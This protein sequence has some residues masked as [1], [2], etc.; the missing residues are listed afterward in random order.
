MT[1][2]SKQGL[3]LTFDDVSR[4]SWLR[5]LWKAWLSTSGCQGQTLAEASSSQFEIRTHQGPAVKDLLLNVSGSLLTPGLNKTTISCEYMTSPIKLRETEWKF[6]RLGTRDKG[7]ENIFQVDEVMWNWRR[8]F[9]ISYVLNYVCLVHLLNSSSTTKEIF[10]KYLKCSILLYWTGFW[11]NTTVSFIC[12]FVFVSVFVFAFVF[13]YFMIISVARP[14][15]HTTALSSTLLD[16][17]FPL[18]PRSAVKILHKY[19]SKQIFLM[20]LWHNNTNISCV[21]LTQKRKY[22]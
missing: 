2:N 13:V 3:R 10:Q 7:Q 9:S 11:H 14:S 16:Q 12:A 1:W 15:L 17:I 19:L 22:S 18:V 4:A 5:N 6:Q 8:W 20:F 21:S